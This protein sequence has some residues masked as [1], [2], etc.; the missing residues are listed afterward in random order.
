MSL[1]H[2]NEDYP[3]KKLTKSCFSRSMIV[4]TFKAGEK[5]LPH[6]IG[7]KHKNLEYYKFKKCSDIKDGKSSTIICKKLFYGLFT[8]MKLETLNF[9]DR[10][11]V[12]YD[13]VCKNRRLDKSLEE[14]SF[15][16]KVEYRRLFDY[17]I[18]GHHIAFLIG[19]KGKF[20]R[21]LKQKYNCQLY[22]HTNK[23]KSHTRAIGTTKLCININYKMLNKFIF[24]IATRVLRHARCTKI[25]DISNFNYKP[26]SV[27]VIRK[28]KEK[29]KVLRKTIPI[30]ASNPHCALGVWLFN[31]N[32]NKLI[33]EYNDTF[34]K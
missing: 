13:R 21:Y 20:I 14:N 22:I 25:R 7:K 8:N 24:D 1:K 23:N 29:G 9:R 2:M 10:L 5:V 3:T 32:L 30:A 6:L 19:K 18:H 16:F 27:Y 12:L 11:K 34:N 15:S 26:K 4:I 33:K 28:Q 31:F 17:Y